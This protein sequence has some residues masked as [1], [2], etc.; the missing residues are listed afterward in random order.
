[1]SIVLRDEQAETPTVSIGMPVYNGEQFI[2][3]ALDSALKQTFSDFELIIADNNSHDATREICCEYMERDSRIKYIRH[4]KNYG[5]YWNFSFVA[6]QATGRFF[7]W[8]AHDDVLEPQFVERTVQYM[9][10]NSRTVIAAADFVIFDENGIELRSEKLEELRDSLTWEI[11]QI[12]FFEFGYPNIHLCFYGMMQ[13]NI[14]K[15]IMAEM[16]IPKMMGGSEYPILARFA[17]SGEIASLPIILRKYR[18]HSSGVYLAEVAE[19]ER[20]P[21]WRRIVFFYGNVFRIRMDLLKVLLSSPFAWKSKFR[22]IRRH[23]LM[24]LQWCRWK[25]TGHWSDRKTIT[26]EAREYGGTD[27]RGFWL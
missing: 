26:E 1:M 27:A 8:L 5:G 17:A 6:R 4:E 24:D 21:K 11:R 12:P 10:Q 19:N 18:S 14:C 3:E 9:S 20:K 22:I 7:T 2:R 25:I 15:A 16:K 23:M 13:T